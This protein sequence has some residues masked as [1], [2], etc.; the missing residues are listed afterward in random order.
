M[1]PETKNCQN[2]K[3]NFVIE[4]DDF[5]FYDK[6]KVPPPTFCPECRMVRRLMW[7]NN[8]SL[9]SRICGLCDKKI[10]SF[11]K[12]DGTPVYCLTCYSSDNWD[13]F[14]YQINY[15]FSKNFFE[16]FKNLIA[17]Q[18]R[19]FQIGLG[20]NTNSEYSNSIANVK[21]LY[22]S[23]SCI[24]SEDIFYSENVDKSKQSMDCLSI[25]DSDNCYW[26]INSEKNFNCSYV[27]DS[28]NCLDSYFLYDC[29][30]CSNCFMSSN[31]RNQSYYFNNK[32]LTK[33]KYFEAIQDLEIGK[34][35]ELEKLKEIFRDLKINQSIHKYTKVQSS[36]DFSGDMILN[37][38]NIKK[39]F[40][41][42][43]SDNVSYSYRTIN[44]KD[45]MDCGWTL[46][47]ELEYESMTGSGGGYNQISC[48]MCTTSKDIRYSISCKNCS[49]CF[50][51][52]GLTNAQYCIL[53]KQYT[54]EEYFEIVEKIKIHMSE[55]PYI[56]SKGRVFKY[57]E[58][59]PYDLS[60]FGY[61]ES[62]A[63]DFFSLT[64]TAI[65]NMGYKYTEPR[66]RNYGTILSNKDLP[67]DIND[68]PENILDETIACPNNGNELTLCTK[69]YKIHENELQ[70]YKQKNLPLPRYCPNCRHYERIKYRNP[71]KL[72]DRSCMKKDCPN[73]FKTSYSPDRPEIVYCEKCY[74]NEVI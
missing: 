15:D 13:R 36:K 39:S 8:R 57:G 7:R 51:C 65:Q 54:K 59:F 27:S 63:H 50:G 28:S 5:V 55:M 74:Q 17:K 31:L 48:F 35:S 71:L 24:E 66:D 44:V 18:P 52:V 40:D 62:L 72:W 73:K 70:F 12:D 10:I 16:Q 47:A 29:S 41:I 33:E 34:Y 61:N 38:N 23:F 67:D 53:N 25:Q 19:I 6:I 43:N 2:C 21:N 30:N 68:V 22:L 1:N 64:K 11:L 20:N 3:N 4:S 46:Q 37:S 42:R 9:Y 69:A 49:D 56:D 32:K 58:F 26:N 45:V 14:A 60:F